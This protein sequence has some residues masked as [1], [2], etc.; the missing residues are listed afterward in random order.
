[1]GRMPASKCQVTVV[2]TDGTVLEVTRADL[3]SADPVQAERDN[4]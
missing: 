1:M 3:E 2:L 4:D